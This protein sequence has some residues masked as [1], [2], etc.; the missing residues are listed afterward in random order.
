M[1]AG[2]ALGPWISTRENHF[3]WEGK[4]HRVGASSFLSAQNTVA[5][6]LPEQ[7]NVLPIHRVPVIFLEVHPAHS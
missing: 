6:S 2:V 1:G 3:E 4:E 5:P 7:M